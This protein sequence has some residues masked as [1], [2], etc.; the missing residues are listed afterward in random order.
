MVTR[1]EFLRSAAVL[2]AGLALARPMAALASPRSSAPARQLSGTVVYWHHYTSESE[3]AGLAEGTASFNAKYPSITIQS[4]TIPNADFMAKFTL[5]VQGGGMPDTT[6]IAA[7]RTPDMV[8]MGGLKDLTDRIAQWELKQYFPDNRFDG[9]RVNG[10]I[11]GVPS[12]MF[13]NW[14]YYRVDWFKEAGLEVPKTFD[15]FTQAA[16]KLTD[17]SKNRYGFGLRGGAGGQGM[18]IEVIRAFGSPI[19]DD[20]G[21]PAM[22]TQKAIEAITWYSELFTKH[23]V[24]PPS[25]PNDSYRQ[26][27]EAFRTGQTAMV[28]HHT[29][30]LAE[31]QGD[32]GSDGTKFMSAPRPAGPAAHIADVS[33]SYNGLV[34]PKNEEA[35]WAWITHWAEADVQIAFLE[36]TGYFPSSTAIA[37]DPRIVNNPYYAAAIETLKFGTMPPAFPGNPGWQQTV[38][39]PSFQK[40]LLGEM[41]PAQAVEAMQK[42]LEEAVNG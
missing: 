37:D 29:G 4:E 9:A 34:D 25:A 33:T 36:K 20:Q 22:D 7:E 40:V 17:P 8:A 28:W 19:V 13:V 42:G 35:A 10:R 1:R 24:V 18:I 5:A 39:L 27:M 11:Y 6:M 41:T 26:I 38:V 31:V 12:F 32:L 23:K 3:M 2:G 15:E 30:S 14:M 21:K 16:I